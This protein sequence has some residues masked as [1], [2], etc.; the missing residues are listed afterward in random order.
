M[1][2]FGY[3]A[4]S[5]LCD[6]ATLRLCGK[7]YARAPEILFHAKPLSR[8]VAKKTYA[9]RPDSRRNRFCLNAQRI[10]TAAVP[11][12]ISINTSIT[13]PVRAG[14]KLWLVSSIDATTTVNRIEAA[15][16]HL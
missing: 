11:P 3:A 4:K 10:A 16:G 1:E 8:K 13:E 12:A 9:G 7:P 14:L 5:L 2:G 15:N 6:F